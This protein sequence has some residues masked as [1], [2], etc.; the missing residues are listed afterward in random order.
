MPAPCRR[1]DLRGSA[2][3]NQ[4]ASVAGLVAAILAITVGVAAFGPQVGSA[5]AANWVC[6][7]MPGA[8]CAPADPA[9]RG[10]GLMVTTTSPNWPWPPD[11]FLWRPRTSVDLRMV[12]L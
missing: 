8:T 4:S 5:V 9:P 7:S 2:G 6:R 3:V 12:S 10:R 1:L 11:C